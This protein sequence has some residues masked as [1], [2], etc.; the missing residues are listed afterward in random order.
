MAGEP[1]STTA[2]GAARFLPERSPRV[3]GPQRSW[4]AARAQQL[5]SCANASATLVFAVVV[6]MAVDLG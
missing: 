1:V 2:A 4:L 3:P 6:M 5:T